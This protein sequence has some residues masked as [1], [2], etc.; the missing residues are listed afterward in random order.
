MKLITKIFLTS[1]LALLSLNACKKKED[2]AP[3]KPS[4]VFMA[5]IDGKS[6]QSDPSDKFLVIDGDTAYGTDCSLEADTLSILA[7]RFSDTSGIIGQLVLTSGRTGTY[8]GTTTAD[9]GLLYIQSLDLAG[10]FG[11]LLGYTTTYN[12]NITKWDATNKKFSG[13]YSLTMVPVSAGAT[14]TV[15]NGEFIDVPYTLE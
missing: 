1:S 14:I 3:T 12:V 9:K 15:T 4:K 11:A 13:T 2:P 7:L 6:W 8:S 10:I 5:T